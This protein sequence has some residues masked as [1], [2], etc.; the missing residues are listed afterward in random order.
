MAIA[1]GVVAVPMIYADRRSVQTQTVEVDWLEESLLKGN[2]SSVDQEKALKRI[3]KHPYWKMLPPDVQRAVEKNREGYNKSGL[4]RYVYSRKLN[5]F[6]D[7][8]GYDV[9]GV[10]PTMWQHIDII[11]APVQ[12]PPVNPKTG[13]P[14]VAV[15][16]SVLAGLSDVDRSYVEKLAFRLNENIHY[17]GNSPLPRIDLGR[18][19]RG[20]YVLS[21]V[22]PLTM[23][24][25]KYITSN[26]FMKNN[27]TTKKEQIETFNLND[28]VAFDLGHRLL[29]PLRDPRVVYPRGYTGVKLECSHRPRGRGGGEDA[30]NPIFLGWSYYLDKPEEI[31]GVYRTY[32]EESHKTVQFFMKKLREEKARITDAGARGMAEKSLIEQTEKIGHQLENVLEKELKTYKKTYKRPPRTLLDPAGKAYDAFIRKQTRPAVTVVTGRRARISESSQRQRD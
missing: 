30:A 6:L 5:V 20:K 1:A 3:K 4:R 2:L 26:Y 21:A 7:S 22:L 31:S 28:P 27:Q 10:I 19:K 13:R 9:I 23:H 14:Y 17:L 8:D 32:L 29:L 11:N 12:T 18:L 24:G 16:D 15:A 25:S